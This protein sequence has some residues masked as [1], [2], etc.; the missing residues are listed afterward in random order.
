MIVVFHPA[1]SAI[2]EIACEIG[3]VSAWGKLDA[4]RELKIDETDPL[5]A[6]LAESLCRPQSK[7]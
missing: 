4:S 3:T 7:S 6:A 1:P 5:P 2:C